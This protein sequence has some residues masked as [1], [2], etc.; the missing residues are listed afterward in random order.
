MIYRFSAAAKF[1]VWK[2]LE[3]G[4]TVFVGMIHVARRHDSHSG[5]AFTV[6]GA[7]DSC[8]SSL[9]LHTAYTAYNSLERVSEK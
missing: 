6:L 7:Y 2:G 4:F 8:G 3:N 1:I 5:T 9:A